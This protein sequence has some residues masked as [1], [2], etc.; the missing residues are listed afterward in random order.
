MET[1]ALMHVAAQVTSLSC[2]SGAQVAAWLGWREILHIDTRRGDY[3]GS[4]ASARQLTQTLLAG[5]EA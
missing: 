2:L 5:L 3:T 4:D 1:S